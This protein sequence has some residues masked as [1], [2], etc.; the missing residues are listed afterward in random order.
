VL[1]TV[2]SHIAAADQKAAALLTIAGVLIAF[3]T[4]TILIPATNPSTV[5]LFSTFCAVVSACAFVTSIYFALLVLFPKTKNKTDT[6]SLIYF[7]DIAAMSK[8]DFVSAIERADAS[9]VRDDLLAQIHINSV[10][11]SLKHSRF[12]GA[13]AALITGI[14]FLAACYV[15]IGLAA[16]NRPS[17]TSPPATEGRP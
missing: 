10:I 4:P 17:P 1:A 7:G 8:T 11:A 2:L 12:K 13:V 6:S 5:P 15:G 14:V 9:R 16:R 3:P